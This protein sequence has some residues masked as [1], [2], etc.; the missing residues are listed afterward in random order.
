MSGEVDI[1]V[2]AAM[3][4]KRINALTREAVLLES[5]VAQL[6]NEN[7][8]LKKEVAELKATPAETKQE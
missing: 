1:N 5:L 7:D 3:M 4:E 2:Y 8:A 6:T